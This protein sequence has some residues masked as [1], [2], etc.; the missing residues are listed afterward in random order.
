MRRRYAFNNALE[1]SL[2]YYYAVQVQ[3]HR[4][5]ALAAQ[6]NQFRPNKKI[7]NYSHRAITLL[8]QVSFSFSG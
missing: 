3:E 7:H 5:S 6:V 8:S 1:P 2:W 4:S